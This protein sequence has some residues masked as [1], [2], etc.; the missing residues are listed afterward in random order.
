MAEGAGTKYSWKDLG[1]AFDLGMRPASLAVGALGIVVALIFEVILEQFLSGLNDYQGNRTLLLGLAHAVEAV[2]LLLIFFITVAAQAY[3]ARCEL[4]E[5]KS[6]RAREAFA[7]VGRSFS[8]LI[9]T[10]LVPIIF[11]LLFAAPM[12]LAALLGRIPYLGKPLYG[13]IGL[14]SYLG[15]AGA[16]MAG[17]LLIFAVYVGPGVVAVRREGAFEATIDVIG[18]MRGR[19]LLGLLLGVAAT[20]FVVKIF[21]AATKL[22]VFISEWFMGAERF[23]DLVAKVPQI[24]VL[25]RLMGYFKIDVPW[26]GHAE[27]KG[28]LF[29]S[30]IFF[31]PVA[32]A[33]LLIAGSYV[34]GVFSAAC[35]ISFLSTIAD[36]D[37]DMPLEPAVPRAPEAGAEKKEEKPVVAA[38]AK[39]EKKKE[40]EKEEKKEPE[41]GEEKEEKEEKKEKEEKEEEQTFVPSEPA[42]EKKEA[43][44]RRKARKTR[45]RR[46]RKKGK[47]SGKP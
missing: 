22:T 34:L 38:A 16:V 5:E 24:E 39:E 14:F 40:K 17:I 45:K 30:L 20:G 47:D 32:F 8:T 31:A 9:A 46:T 4:L 25:V 6:V 18:T 21:C 42:E 35:T 37:W 26:L 41:K 19:G 33:W 11:G 23:H 2:V 12:A 29:V 28:F 3:V 13:V 1:S 44:G 27:T 15:M 10:P 43:K 7:F 36:E